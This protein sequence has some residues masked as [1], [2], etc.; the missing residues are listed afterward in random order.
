MKTHTVLIECE[1]FNFLD[2]TVEFEIYWNSP[3][4]F[5]RTDF[6]RTSCIITLYNSVTLGNSSFQLTFA[7]SKSTIEP[8]EKGAEYVQS[9]Q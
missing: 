8:L 3:V 6:L 9:Y 2:V 1:S 5:L 7:F 4:Q